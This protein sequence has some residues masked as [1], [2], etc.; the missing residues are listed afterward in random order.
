MKILGI[1]WKWKMVTKDEFSGNKQRTSRKLTWLTK[2]RF[3]REYWSANRSV[4]SSIF[5][6]KSS[7]KTSVLCKG[8][9]SSKNESFDFCNQSLQ[10]PIDGRVA[11]SFRFRDAQHDQ[12]LGKCHWS[13][14]SWR[15]R[16]F[17]LKVSRFGL[18]AFIKINLAEISRSKRCFSTSPSSF[19]NLEFAFSTSNPSFLRP[20]PFQICNLSP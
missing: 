9:I 1:G 8:S 2:R 4:A 17:N 6:P 7:S 19:P 13:R 12:L 16:C 18:M 15:S 10:R 11:F 5:P 14:F 3:R 20:W